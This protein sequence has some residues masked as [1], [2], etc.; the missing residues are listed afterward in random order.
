MSSLLLWLLFDDIVLD[1]ESKRDERKV[2]FDYGL[3]VG[4][5]VCWAL[6]VQLY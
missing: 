3:I 5:I 2:Q 6:Q 1:A 4:V